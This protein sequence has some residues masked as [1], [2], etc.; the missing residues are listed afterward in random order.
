[1]TRLYPGGPTTRQAWMGKA[2]RCHLGLG[3]LYR[4]TGQQEAAANPLA[5]AATMFRDMGMR[6][7]LE[8]ATAEMDDGSR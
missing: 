5:T 2:A 4:A 3:M 8:K 1:M 7:W 6:S